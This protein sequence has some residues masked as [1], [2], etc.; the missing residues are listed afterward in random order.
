ML[1]SGSVIIS[2]TIVH[3]LSALF[4]C[5]VAVDIFSRIELMECDDTL[6]LERIFR[7]RRKYSLKLYVT[8]ATKAFIVLCVKHPSPSVVCINVIRY[9]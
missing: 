8:T 6:A 4:F 9:L 1:F 5:N 7:D 2:P 3:P